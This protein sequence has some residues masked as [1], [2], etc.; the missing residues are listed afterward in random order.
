MLIKKVIKKY[1]YICLTYM[2]IQVHVIHIHTMEVQHFHIVC[3]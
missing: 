3:E 1:I 2:L